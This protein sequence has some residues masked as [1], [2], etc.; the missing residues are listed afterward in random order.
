MSKSREEVDLTAW[1]TIDQLPRSPVE[2]AGLAQ[3][4]RP[5]SFP[6]FEELLR[7]GKD[8]DSALSMFLQEFYQHRHPSFFEEPPSPHLSA[9]NRAALA[10][11]SEWLCHRYGYEG[12]AWTEKPEFFF[13]SERKWSEDWDTSDELSIVLQEAFDAE[14]DSKHS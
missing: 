14:I 2:S 4:G 7:R 5:K 8:R 6:E 12:P 3:S 10:G 11:A 13:T 9:I 1:K